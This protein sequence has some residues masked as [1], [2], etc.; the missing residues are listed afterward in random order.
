[1]SLENPFNNWDNNDSGKCK[2]KSP[3]NLKSLPNH[4]EKIKIENRE[5]NKDEKQE[6]GKQEP[7]QIPIVKPEQLSP[8][9]QQKNKENLKEKEEE[10]V[11]HFEEELQ[12]IKNLPKEKEWQKFN[13][14]KETKKLIKDWLPFGYID[15]FNGIKELLSYT[16]EN[17]P[18]TMFW[19]GWEKEHLAKN[20]LYQMAIEFKMDEGFEKSEEE[21]KE[22]RK[23]KIEN[24]IG[25]AEIYLKNNSLYYQNAEELEKYL[26]QPPEKYKES[27][28]KI[29]YSFGEQKELEGPDLSKI[30]FSLKNLAKLTGYHDR[31]LAETAKIL[32][33]QNLNYEIF[34]PLVEKIENTFV[35]TK[36]INEIL[37]LE[38]KL[39]EERLKYFS[40]ETKKLVISPE[41]PLKIDFLRDI[42]ETKLKSVTIPEELKKIF[43]NLLT[44]AHLETTNAD[45]QK[46]TETVKTKIDDL[47]TSKENLSSK[48]QKLVQQA[49]DAIKKNR[50]SV[51]GLIGSGLGVSFLLMIILAIIGEFKLLE[52]STGLDLGG[53]GGKS[54][55]K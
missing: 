52:K 5:E 46:N 24:M 14:Y 15:N 42:V 16:E 19:Y 54:K 31:A 9:E 1:M 25:F 28:K 55:K 20:I 29:G 36:T 40:E 47:Q 12:K 50:D 51:W 4:S 26:T 44:D 34:Q 33:G 8:E 22:R 13:I 45:F 27:R 10:I 38:E 6:K 11:S 23:G 48:E 18:K 37:S 32:C 39:P 3:D 30:A 17:K 43:I 41:L 21:L 53:E 7:G 49:K 2:S 35:K